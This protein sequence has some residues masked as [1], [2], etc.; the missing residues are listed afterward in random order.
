MTDDELIQ[1]AKK[2]AEVYSA[3]PKA[4]VQLNHLPKVRL[5]ET[6]VV[7][8]EGEPADGRIEVVLD[9]QSGDLIQAS[10]MPE[11][12]CKNKVRV[13]DCGGGGA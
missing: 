7:S 3:Q 8:F 9:R 1:I 10:L 6:V 13:L 2:R 4:P 5:R 12:A 11:K